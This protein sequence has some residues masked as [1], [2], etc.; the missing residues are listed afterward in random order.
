MY[1]IIL[2]NLDKFRFQVKHEETDSIIVNSIEF[3]TEEERDEKARIFA[4]TIDCKI[5]KLILDNEALS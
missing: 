2:F 4:N 3:D 5:Y 1:E